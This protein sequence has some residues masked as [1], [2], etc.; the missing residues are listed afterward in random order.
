[1]AMTPPSFSRNRG[2]DECY[3]YLQGISILIPNEEF[4]KMNTL[5]KKVRS[6][7]M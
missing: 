2:N 5:I 4:D 6:K 1:M 3:L 7:S